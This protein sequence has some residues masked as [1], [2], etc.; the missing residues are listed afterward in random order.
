MDPGTA[1]SVASL[2]YD[3][4]KDLYEYYRTWKDCEKD[5]AELRETLLWLHHAF[6]VSRDVVRQSELSVQAVEPLYT[7]LGACDDTANDLQDILD[8]IKS[9]GTPQT[10][11]AKLKANG[12]KAC[13]PFRKPTVV[14]VK[15]HVDECCDRLHLAVGLLH[16]DTAGHMHKVL[17]ELDTKLVNGFGAVDAALEQLPAIESTVLAIHSQASAVKADTAAIMDA[18]RSEKQSNTVIE[19]M[20]WLCLADYSHQQNDIYARRQEGTA[21]WFLESNEYR[22]WIQ[23][24]AHTLVC[25][26]QPG[27]GKTIVAATVIHE[28]QQKED[29][30]CVG[31]AYLFCHYKRQDEQ[32][33]HH[34]LGA[35]TR[36]LLFQSKTTPASL[37]HS[38]AKHKTRNTRHSQEE[39]MNSLSSLARGFQKV[40]FVV[41][42]LDECGSTVCTELLSMIR[43][44][45]VDNNI[46]LLVTTRPLREVLDHVPSCPTLEVRASESDVA[47]YLK[48]RMQTLPKFVQT[49]PNLQE[50]LITAIVAAVAG[51]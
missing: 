16:L 28:L 15:A 40:Y 46:S 35:L 21:V 19:M 29:L 14:A 48:A 38:Y 20:D 8:K 11:W 36:Q 32:D 50:K 51:M 41:D 26:G 27:A 49:D 5:V 43:R 17:K 12:R 9:Q 25:P 47:N 39:L 24:S 7:A 42:A 2:A 33:T 13:Y 10:T 3:V 6:K 44:L 22:A 23:G 18:Q 30:T 45:Q 34:F 31:I 4:V 1:L 37:T